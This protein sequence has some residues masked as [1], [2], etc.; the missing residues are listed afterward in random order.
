MLIDKINL[1][2]FLPSRILGGAE[3]QF[4]NIAN[5]LSTYRNINL[6][7]IDSSKQHIIKGIKSN[8][9]KKIVAGSKKVKVKKVIW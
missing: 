3:R 1:T 7:V 4:I 8:N 6:T 2:L 5:L 9:V